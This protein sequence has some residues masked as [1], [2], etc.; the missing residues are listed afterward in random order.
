MSLCI[1]GYYLS[2]LVLLL[3]ILMG[4]G[5]AIVCRMICRVRTIAWTLYG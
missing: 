3:G 5:I 4:V 1:P 2:P